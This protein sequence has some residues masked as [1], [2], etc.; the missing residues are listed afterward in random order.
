MTPSRAVYRRQK[1]F[2]AKAYRTG[3]HGWP[4]EKPTPE[5]AAFLRRV[6][7]RG[8]RALDLGCGEGRHSILLARLGARVDAVD[9]ERGA[10]R[11]AAVFARR[12]GVAGRIRFRKAD[13]L[14]L[15]FDDAAFDVV[16]DYGCFHHVVKPDW[17]RYVREISR[18][19]RPGGRLVLSVFSMK[20]RHYE[21][22][23]RTRPWLYHR[24]HYDRF[25]NRG[26]LAPIFAPAFD[27]VAIREEHKGL[28]GFWHALLRKSAERP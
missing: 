23:K 17:K 22:E 15:P 1:T 18:V 6:V 13:A 12:A 14:D 9:Y 25:F 24:N 4:V 19:L 8:D 16:V 5:V 20:F 10:L 7:R 11:K 28:S 26:D 3:E 2:F 27:L 21:G